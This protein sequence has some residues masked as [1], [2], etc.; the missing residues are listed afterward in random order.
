[1]I[2]RGGN[3]RSPNDEDLE[4]RVSRLFVIGEPIAKLEIR[5][6]FLNCF[7]WRGSI[8]HGNCASGPLATSAT[9]TV[10]HAGRGRSLSRCNAETGSHWSPKHP[11]RVFE[12]FGCLKHLNLDHL[13]AN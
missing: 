10:P 11:Q 12:R 2:P 13:W 1:M 6:F 4:L 9:S 3:E 8:P 7:C 5:G